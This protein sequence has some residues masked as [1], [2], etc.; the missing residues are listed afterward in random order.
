MRRLIQTLSAI[1]MNSF[2]FL[3]PKEGITLYQGKLKSVCVPILN[4][5]SCPL[6]WGSCPIGAAQQTLKMMKIPYFVIGFFAF[7]GAFIGRYA[8][9]NFCPFGFLQEMLY[10]IKTKK[11]RIKRVFRLTKFA[12]LALTLSLPLLVHQPVFCKFLCPAGTLE[13]SIAQ[14]AMTPSLLQSIGFI[15]YLKALLAVAFIAGS[16]SMKRFF[17][18]TLCPIG[19]IYGLFNKIS[20]LQIK[21]DESKCT[22]CG[23]CNHVCP[24]DINIYENTADYDCIRCF[25]CVNKCPYNALSKGTLFSSPSSQ[26][27]N[28]VLK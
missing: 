13:A 9:G 16:I 7:I 26:E 27:K 12:V 19:A 1:V 15:F 8:C 17:C 21:Y 22:K 11:I 10:K 25:E 2:V 6:A 4:C 28:S 14:I 20:L 18:S 3:N 5:Y 24:M 23:V